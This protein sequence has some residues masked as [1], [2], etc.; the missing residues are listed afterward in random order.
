MATVTGTPPVVL[1]DGDCAMCHAG[2]RTILRRE[3]APELRFASLTSDYATAL[4]ASR[5]VTP[6]A[7]TMVVVDGDR[8]LLRSDAVLFVAGK[9]RAPWRWARALKCLPRAWRDALYDAVAARRRRWF[10]VAKTDC[11]VADAA[12][13]KRFLA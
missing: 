9:L 10:G 1:F 3:R 11:P 13:R 6:P 2:V 12:T 5:G 7:R 4:F 8:L